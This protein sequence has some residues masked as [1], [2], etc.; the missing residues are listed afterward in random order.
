ML[1]L[2]FT[3]SGGGCAMMREAGIRTS[4]KKTTRRSKTPA[5]SFPFIYKNSGGFR[6][7]KYRLKIPI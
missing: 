6:C 3:G 5:F 7:I 4:K 1:K 2:Q